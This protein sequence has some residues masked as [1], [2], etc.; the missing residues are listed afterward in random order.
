MGANSISTTIFEAADPCG[1]PVPALGGR[2]A[3][4]LGPAPTWSRWADLSKGRR[5]VL[6]ESPPALTYS[7]VWGPS[8]SIAFPY[9]PASPGTPNMS[10]TDW[11]QKVP[12]GPLC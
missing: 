10:G 9:H 1:T 7:G 12:T 5:H 4:T 2:Q 11:R 3:Q 6:K 8:R